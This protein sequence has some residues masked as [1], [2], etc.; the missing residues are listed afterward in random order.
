MYHKTSLGSIM[1]RVRRD[2]GWHSDTHEC[3]AAYRST[4][5]AGYCYSTLGFLLF[6]IA[7]EEAR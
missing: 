4:I 2:G 7:S 5:K 3:S 6:R 1:H